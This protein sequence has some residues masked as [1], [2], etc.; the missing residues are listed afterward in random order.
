LERALDAELVT[1]L[2][3]LEVL[4]VLEIG[5]DDRVAGIEVEHLFSILPATTV[6]AFCTFG[7][8]IDLC[9]ESTRNIALPL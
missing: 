3:I 6:A 4:D 7:A 2:L 9:C 1:D 8:M 5:F